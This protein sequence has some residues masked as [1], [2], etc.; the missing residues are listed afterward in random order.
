MKEQIHQAV[1]LSR[2]PI[3]AILEVEAPAA[4]APAGGAAEPA[5]YE[6]AQLL[7][8]EVLI[9]DAGKAMNT[10]PSAR[11]ADESARG[12]LITQPSLCQQVQLP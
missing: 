7:K 11:G 6:E 8:D 12:C 9:D 5:Q 2:R 4:A 1:D 10:V 3:E